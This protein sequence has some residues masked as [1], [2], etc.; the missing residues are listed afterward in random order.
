MSE[1]ENEMSPDP[2]QKGPAQKL[3]AGSFLLACNGLSDPN[4]DSTIVLLCQYGPEGG[5]GLVLNRPSHMPLVELFDNP[6]ENALLASKN[7][8]VYIGGPVQPVDLQVLQIGVEAAPGSFEIAPE[9]HLGGVWNELEEVL[10]LDPKKTR[11]FLGYSGWGAGQLEH[12][13]QLGAWEVY[14]AD[15]KKLLLGPEEEWFG[16]SEHFKRFLKTL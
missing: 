16:G 10:S 13:I 15:V 6:P 12:E 14:Q 7:R 5:Y 3:Q 9:I 8:R 1:F 11:F 4:F 2:G